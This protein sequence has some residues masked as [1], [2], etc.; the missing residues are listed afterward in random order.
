M[1][2]YLGISSSIPII[3]HIVAD[4]ARKCNMFFEIS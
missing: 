2:M 1:P 4:I 3:P